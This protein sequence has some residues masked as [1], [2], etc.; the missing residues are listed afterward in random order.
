MLRKYLLSV[1]IIITCFSFAQTQAQEDK[2][3]IYEEPGTAFF[4]EMFGKFFYSVNI[5]LPINKS[6]RY[7]FGIS[8]TYGDIVPTA[9]YYH[10]SGEKSSFE[11]GCGFGYVI[12]LT[13]EDEHEDF[14]GLTFH[15]VIGYRYQ[16][17]NGLLFRVG[18][19][20]LMFG[21]KIYPFFGLSIGYSM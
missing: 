9:M 15:G 5:D 4:F 6:N 17:K 14:K 19:T 18:F 20:P 3:E 16:K 8:P 2:I 13:D 7:G 1:V 21:S 12:I 10:L 11:I